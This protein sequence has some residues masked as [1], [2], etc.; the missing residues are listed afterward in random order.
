MSGGA[1]AG[2]AFGSTVWIATGAVTAASGACAPA[3]AP[4]GGGVERE[5]SAAGAVARVARAGAAPTARAA[6]TRTAVS[7]TAAM[8]SARALIEVH[9]IAG[10]RRAEPPD[11]CVPS[12]DAGHPHPRTP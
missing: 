7:A 6:T 9:G 1:L 2:G 5:I 8:T 3:G 4:A 11:D 12:A 10:V